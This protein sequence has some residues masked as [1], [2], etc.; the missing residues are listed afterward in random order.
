MKKEIFLNYKKRKIRII[1]EECNLW[2]KF[3]GLMFSRGE[4]AEIL[5][6]SFKRKQK[7]NIHSFF[8]FFRF[9]AL[10]LDNKNSVIDMKIVRPFTLSISQKPACNLIEIPFNKKN[11]KLINFFTTVGK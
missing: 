8:V 10:W 1:A 5:L 6:F 3:K 11:K 4:N 2:R 9:V 7:I